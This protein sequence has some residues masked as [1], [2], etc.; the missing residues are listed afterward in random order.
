MVKQLY[1][2]NIEDILALTPMQQGMLFHYL[3]DPEG[4]YYVEQLCLEISGQID[5]NIMVQAWNDV[6]NTN[7]MLRTCFR[8]DQV[9]RPVQIVLRKNTVK[10]R[11]HDLASGGSRDTREYLKEIERQDKNEAFDLNEV[12][13]RVTLCK[14]K[15]NR[16]RMIIS[17]HHI[18]YDGWSNG[19]ILW[20]FLTYYNERLH[21]RLPLMEN[22]S[23]LKDFTRWI[24]E[25]DKAGEEKF[26]KDYLKGLDTPTNLSIKR[27]GSITGS[28]ARGKIEFHLSK[29]MQTGLEEF[30]KKQKITLASLFY[31]AW[32]ILSQKYNNNED[33]VFG[34]TVAGRS[35]AINGIERMVGLFINTL[36]LRIQIHPREHIIDLILKIKQHLEQREKF[37]HTSLVNIKKYCGA[38]N[39]EELFGEIVTLENYPLDKE[40]RHGEDFDIES[41]SI[42]GVTHYDLSLRI[43]LF[44]DIE[45]N[46]IYAQDLFD[47]GIIISLSNHFKRILENIIENHE[48]LAADIEI[49]SAAEKNQLL[50]EFN[51][52]RADYPGTK[53][54]NQLFEDQVSGT[55]DQIAVLQ[56][57]G[58]I[59]SI[60]YNQLNRESSHIG[61]LLREE[62]V[63]PN[64]IVALI[65]DRSV[66]MVA[67]MLAILKAGAAYLPIN[68]QYPPGRIKLILE[69]S[70]PR[71]ILTQQHLHTSN[72]DRLEAFPG[73]RILTFETARNHSRD[74]IDL[75]AINTPRDLAYVIYTSGTTGKP[76]GV[77][78]DHR[79][80]V[81]VVTW[82]GRKYRL[83]YGVHVLQLSDYTFDASVNQVFGTL[84]HGA[85]LHEIDNPLI[86]DI[87]GLR[88]Y[89]D[90]HQV[91]VINFVPIFL[92]HLLC[93][94]PKL[95]SLHTVISGADTLN[96]ITKNNIIER[97][98][99]LYNQYGPTE[100]T[101]DALASR[102]SR[103][104]VTL[105]TPIANAACYI[106]DKNYR[107]MP[108]GV[109]G[110]LYISGIG[111]SR[112]YLN[113]PQLTAE[114]FLYLTFKKKER[115]YRSGD[116]ARWLAA[117]EIEF[118]G[119]TDDQVKIK[120][121][122]IEP[123]EI[124]NQLKKNKTVKEAVVMIRKNEAGDKSLC[125]YIVPVT[126]GDV[127]PGHRDVDIS[128][129]KRYLSFNLPGYMI[130]SHLI[131]VEKIPLTPNG[132]I[133]KAALSA[134]GLQTGNEYIPPRDK[135]EV[136]L[137][138]IWSGVLN[139]DETNISV[140]SSFFDLGGHSL[141]AMLAIS[142]IH[143]DFN[144][145]V[146][147]DQLFK[148]PTIRQLSRYIKEAGKDK[149]SS[150]DPIE[151]K[152]FYELSSAQKRLFILQELDLNSTAYNIA[153]D[154]PVGENPGKLKLDSVIKKL[155]ERHESLRISFIK[156]NEIPV[157]KIHNKVDFS[158]DYFEAD[159][160]EARQIIKNYKRPFNLSQAPL[161]RMGLVKLPFNHHIMMLDM[162]HIIA[163]GTSTT[164]LVKDFQALYREEG[165]P[166]LKIHYKDFSA[167]QNRF[168]SSETVKAQ[169]AY[170]LN[171]FPSPPPH[172]D[173]PTDYIRPE[174]FT[175]E[176]DQYG[177][178]LEEGEVKTFK[179]LALSNGGTLY[180]NILAVLNT[181]FYKYTGQTDIVIGCGTAGRTHSDLP[182]IIGMFI[183]TLAQRNY[184]RGEKTYR[185]FLKEVI[186][187]SIDAFEN[188]DL[189]FEELVDLID[190]ERD[191]SRNPL[192]DIMMIVQNFGVEKSDK[193][194]PTTRQP[195]IEA[196]HELKTSR[197]KP[198]DSR[199]ANRT[200]KFD[201]TFYII[202][203]GEDVLI[204]IEYY[205]AIFK[206]DTIVRMVKHFKNII[207]QAI[208]N[209][210]IK[211]GEIDLLTQQERH[212]MLYRFN[213]I[214]GDVP[215]EG[216]II[217][218]FE[219]R[220]KTIPHHTAVVF[221]EDHLTYRSLDQQANQL[222]HY[223]YEVNNR[224][225][226]P[227]VGLLMDR[228]IFVIAVV[229][230]IL[231]TNGAYVP[232]DPS[233]PG[234]RIKH[235]IND[236]GLKILVG[237]K[238]YLKLLN[239]L[240]W[241]CRNL[242][243]FLCVDSD[244][245]PRETGK[246]AGEEMEKLRDYV[247]NTSVDQVTG[248]G[249]RSSYTGDPMSEQEMD[250]FAN[251]VL[252]KL[253][254]LLHKDMR[255]LEIGVASGITMYRIAPA[256]GLYY[257]T[258]LSEVMIKK[259]RRQ[260]RDEGR[261]NIK[262]R[263]LAAHEIH[264]LEEKDFDLV[265]INS[266]IQYFDGHNYLRTVLDRVIDL[267]KPGS[268]CYLFI[269]DIM[270]LELKDQLTA[271]LETFKQINIGGNHRTKTDWSQE[272]FISRSFLE[273]LLWDYPAIQKVEFSAKIHT[274]E[275]ELTKYR[276][277]A[278]M[279]IHKGRDKADR[280]KDLERHKHQHDRRHLSTY[281]IE[282]P[283]L[284][285][286]PGNLAYVIYTS[287]STGKP[288]GVMVNRSSVLNLLSELHRY[289][290]LME[291]DVYL[292]KTSYAFD[293]SVSELFGWF[294][295]GGRL[296][297]LER[298]GEKDP[299]RIIEAIKNYR[300]THVN[301][302]PS[303]FNAFAASLNRET[304][305]HLSRLKYIFLAGEALMPGMMNQFKTPWSPI[306]LENLYGPTEG[307]VYASK[308]ALS[309]WDGRSRIPIGKPLANVILSI[310]DN[311]GHLQPIGIPGEL[312]IHGAG[313]ARGYLNRPELTVEKFCPRRV[314]GADALLWGRF[315]A[316]GSRRGL[317][318]QVK[319]WKTTLKKK[320]T[321]IG[322][323]CHGTPRTPRKNFSL[324]GAHKGYMQS[325]NHAAM[326]LSTHHSPLFPIY[327]TGDLAKWRPDGNIEFLGRSDHQVKIRGF[328]IEPG[329]IENQLLEHEIVKETVVVVI[330]DETRG[331]YLC[332][333]IVAHPPGTLDHPVVSQ[334]KE[335]LSKHLPGY[336]I[337][338]YFVQLEELPLTPSG[339]V[340]RK[341]LPLP[342]TGVSR[343][344]YMAPQNPNEE[345]L[346]E[347]WSEILGM[348]KNQVS[349]NVNFFELGGNSL[350]ANILVS[351]IH[352][353]L[354]IKIS[355]QEVF[356]NQTIKRLA[357]MI[358]GAEKSK[359]T[360]VEAIEKK[361]YYSL[362]PAQKRIYILQQMDRRGTT[363]LIPSLWILEGNINKNR[364]KETIF[365][366][367][368]RHE[369]LRTS[370]DI[371]RD[372]PVQGVHDKVKFDIQYRNCERAGTGNGER[373]K[374]EENTI[375]NVLKHFTGPF[376]LS[377]AP[378]LRVGLI[379]EEEKKHILVIN[380]HHIISDGV[381]MSILVREFVRLYQGEKLAELHLQYKDFAQ[382]QNRWLE[383]AGMKRQAEYWSS[384]FAGDI[385][386]LN[387]PTDYP[388]PAVKSFAGKN[389]T[390][391]IDKEL[392]DK[393]KQM[394][395]ETGTTLFMVLLATYN[396]LLSQYTEQEDIIVGIPI[397]GR[398][399]ADLEHVIGMFVNTLATRNYPR[400]EYTF[401]DFLQKVKEN[402]LNAHDNQD[403]PLEE[404][405]D[406]LNITRNTGRDPLVEVL[407]VSQNMDIPGLTL[408]GLKFTP[409]HFK[410]QI[411]HLD[412]V[413]YFTE[414][415]N[416]IDFDLEYSTALFKPETARQML[417]HY[418]EILELVVEH[419]EIALKDIVISHDYLIVRSTLLT[420]ENTKFDF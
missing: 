383:S 252:E 368:H 391:E 32:G 297:I 323:P 188:Q 359:F 411:A 357:R 418:I 400:G 209:P 201:I 330:G 212:I 184:P 136:K 206:E 36:P 420:Q 203:E 66:H 127:S 31:T 301:F 175:F 341:A 125:A 33:T 11:Y 388:R 44:D 142:R 85:T 322:P 339:K 88:D 361:E 224:A 12:P 126:G 104:N 185:S 163:D 399:H 21:N 263:C 259:N 320:Q 287:G 164:I 30:V 239:R 25:Q 248:G 227:L 260:V 350:T 91:H 318:V 306:K 101:I 412:L 197:I 50:H 240:Q 138:G 171:I 6:V 255:V 369:S 176:G 409:Y 253:H 271:D 279:S 277:D 293:V 157:Q 95:E 396:L 34:T 401:E 214:Q 178:W 231:K 317:Q 98:Y 314:R 289:Y 386:V 74:D 15:E 135:I 205:T 151:K 159:E 84:V 45:F 221:R 195:G 281:G 228:D 80:A 309:D 174:A 373:S 246:N 371:V 230:G 108:I 210:G 94:G 17:N 53:T 251:N 154:F 43:T 22:K 129:I 150:I 76:R 61:Q 407:F 274:V 353:E 389:V 273:D 24:Q 100:T 202:E 291:Q 238:R 302:V 83:R 299:Q 60:T 225:E 390:F 62:G 187:H 170:W 316:K 208:N 118:L 366:L 343:E 124:E 64:N 419:R 87:Q 27:R 244:N 327:R 7:E 204:A 39:S 180:M 254:L 229:L 114:R 86:T 143:K 75:T 173:L 89:I 3:K 326:P 153:Y 200:S 147:L 73:E 223:L 265:I 405:V 167:W 334:L 245:A 294:F 304:I 284:D 258:D 161:I 217:E 67:G 141:T 313:V 219:T 99:A 169:E 349:I 312:C 410:N 395:A 110:E 362:S 183:N 106:L 387:L 275:N 131:P 181:L 160:P 4:G 26:W 382:W 47:E 193:L 335:H 29:E 97:G 416:K 347:I 296:A 162:H 380:M 408:Q 298:G 319:N 237:Q 345:K 103:H 338:G 137:A 315:S 123:G 370:F 269:G 355:L 331:N 102:C 69:D 107:L 404:L 402:M 280:E 199:F 148:T 172:L 165:L 10:L 35:A 288:K 49:L 415:G 132:K 417:D 393:I 116:L 158:L 156:V 38:T 236:T 328:R 295:G 367:I 346:A 218:R 194:F 46:L 374:K 2:K 196:G 266:V 55:P 216:T 226:E 56:A 41:Y 222:A 235:M 128:Q 292:F 77:M 213:N 59:V 372:E 324:E 168:F 232:L 325:C 394:T 337:P 23:K 397:A 54:L 58:D 311:A 93:S 52:T 145:R 261:Q 398:T 257:G 278:L 92:E 81:N 68:P 241:E 19:I 186:A 384:R 215:Q 5:Y 130:P 179:E 376:D 13:F 115:L 14:I 270:D 198:D 9:N 272:L 152:E 303:M 70:Q 392:T 79:S 121:F 352:K 262:L 256:V 268:T 8:W 90:A 207:K 182:H 282:K 18:L 155:I 133:D 250:E 249:W 112:G 247:G 134:L 191:A 20:E 139:L 211:L 356:K 340:D 307:T 377:K 305:G 78:V 189:Q 310:T 267:L 406:K 381:S 105:G 144:V 63:Y 28:S 111:V 385:P 48:K 40:L 190:L 149:F 348:R 57:A 234:E 42:V 354:N 378:L 146:P 403:Y 220:A 113:R 140:E 192:F 308:Y 379:K 285:A 96:S 358:T 283:V 321:L 122:R 336:M 300:V 290:P 286:A 351:K 82:F 37:E 117:G 109:A 120:G 264:R 119:R 166:H 242:D 233:L 414:T 344:T 332:G 333:Y 276:Y 1:K 375:A 342:R 71:L 365:K 360:S 413:L 51:D 243:T 363:Y 72:R 177:F 16:Y 65:T 364:M 329:E